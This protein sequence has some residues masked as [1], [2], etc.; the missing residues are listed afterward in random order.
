MA[1]S[2]DHVN[3]PEGFTVDLIENLGDAHEALKEMHWLILELAQGDIPKIRRALARYY[4][5][6]RAEGVPRHS[7]EQVR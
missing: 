7:Y 3:G 2:F 1:G 4:R 6:S 5:G